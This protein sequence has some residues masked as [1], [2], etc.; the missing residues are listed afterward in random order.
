MLPFL[1]P[2]RGEKATSRGRCTLTEQPSASPARLLA[3][4]AEAGIEVLLSGSGLRLSG[5][6]RPPPELLES[7][8][9]IKNE[10]VA[11]LT[12]R[13]GKTYPLLSRALRDHGIVVTVSGNYIDM[14]SHI[15]PP[16]DIVDELIAA[17]WDIIRLLGEGGISADRAAQAQWLHDH[18][19]VH[20]RTHIALSGTRLAI[21]TADGSD[22]PAWITQR[23]TDLEDA[24]ITLLAPP[25]PEDR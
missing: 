24:L 25:K 16:A 3:N 18:A 1:S 17:K 8:A 21:T 7:L 20:H 19:W 9:A 12:E 6:R 15:E 22:P 13:Q 2:A 4:L 14:A 5:T 10:V 23:A 11:F